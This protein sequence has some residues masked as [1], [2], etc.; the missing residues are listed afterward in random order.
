[1]PV[2]VI[3]LSLLLM[4]LMAYTAAVQ[5]TIRALG[6]LHRAEG[7][8]ARAARSQQRILL[9]M[10]LTK[11][12]AAFLV[13]MVVYAV[14]RKASTPYHAIAVLLLCWIGALLIASTSRLR[15]GSAQMVGALVSELERRREW[16]R[17]LQDAVR[18][19][20]AE[21][22]LARIHASVRIRATSR[23]NP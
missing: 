5:R 10:Y 15:P 20:A 12:N 2:A 16:Y 9:G 3:L 8:D 21:A 18:L 17:R 13:G 7:A 1:M 14:A 23:S 4:L 19:H 22:L 6:L 11:L